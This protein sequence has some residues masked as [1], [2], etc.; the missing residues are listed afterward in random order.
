MVAA[1]FAGVVVWRQYGKPRSSED[2]SDAKAKLVPVGDTPVQTPVQVL[3]PRMGIMDR[4]DGES[5]W[6]QV[7]QLDH[8]VQRMAQQVQEMN[9][10]VARL[11]VMAQARDI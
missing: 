11:L 6:P 1:A 9:E 2:L 7:Q 3:T 8:D 5:L 10:A 4:E